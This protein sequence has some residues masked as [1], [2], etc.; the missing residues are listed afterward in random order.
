[1]MR[2]MGGSNVLVKALE[3]TSCRQGGGSQVHALAPSVMRSRRRGVHIFS[4]PPSENTGSSPSGETN[5]VWILPL[6][7]GISCCAYLGLGETSR[8]RHKRPLK[9]GSS[10]DAAT[11]WSRDTTWE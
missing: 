6:V 9:Q 2:I 11:M 10:Y 3:T 5:H 7:F 4:G 8:L 1:M